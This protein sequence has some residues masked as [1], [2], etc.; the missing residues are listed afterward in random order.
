MAGAKQGSTAN[1][2]WGKNLRVAVLAGV[3]VEK[4]VC[5]GAFEPRSPA[6]VNREARPRNFCG[7]G[8][9][10]N[11]GAFTDFPVRL[12]RKIELGR[13]SPTTHLDVFLGAM[14]DRDTRVRKI[15]NREQKLLLSPR[16]FDGL[17]ALFPDRLRQAL[18]LSDDRIRIPVFLL[19]PPNLFAGLV[20]FCPQRLRLCN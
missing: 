4:E 3:H 5:Q 2:E 17:E 1:E 13:R 12:R 14:S 7:G 10:E 16:Q 11:P 6:F 15:R 20:A 19:Q 9:I 8:E 18:H